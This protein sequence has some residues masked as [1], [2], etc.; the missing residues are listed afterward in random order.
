MAPAYYPGVP[1]I[2]AASPIRVHG[3]QFAE[4]YDI[5]LPSAP[6]HAVRGKVIDPAGDPVAK[7]SVR[8]LSADTNYLFTRGL[9]DA[10][11]STDRDGQFQFRAVAS[12]KWRLEAEPEHNPGSQ[13]GFLPVLL[14]QS[15]LDGLIVPLTNPFLLDV[16]VEGLPF[17]NSNRLGPTLHLLPVDGPLEQQADSGAPKNGKIQI[18]GVYP[19]RYRFSTGERKGF[20]LDSI[21]FGERDVLGQEV[22][23]AEGAP[24]VRLIYKRDGG[25]V[26][27]TVADGGGSTV[28]LVPEIGSPDYWQAVKSDGQG[29]FEV[30]D[31][32]PGDYYAVAVRRAETLQD[33]GFVSTIERQGERVHVN[34]KETSALDLRMLQ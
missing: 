26:R 30:G 16:A 6:M 1:S 11:V 31:L 18:H 8:L 25:K 32:R 29:R 2:N 22:E 9:A 17:E 21:L 14:M 27:G 4:G 19:G 23:L 20:Y 13:M 10:E 12:G 15:D 33:P 24:P 34:A 7:A 5:R 28:V 3:E